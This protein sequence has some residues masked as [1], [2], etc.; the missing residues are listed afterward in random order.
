[1]ISSPPGS[2]MQLDCVV[3]AVG[4]ELAQLSCVDKRWR[5]SLRGTTTQI[6][7]HPRPPWRQGALATELTNQLTKKVFDNCVTVSNKLN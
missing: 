6:R 3:G 5:S 4:A 7:P 2:P 1:M